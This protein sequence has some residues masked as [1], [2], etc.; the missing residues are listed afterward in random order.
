MHH[1][2]EI[3]TKVLFWLLSQFDRGYISPY[4]V[5]DTEKMIVEYDN[6]R[7]SRLLI[8]AVA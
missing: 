4:F 3:M 2:L 6:A 7:V 8:T 1:L 5:T